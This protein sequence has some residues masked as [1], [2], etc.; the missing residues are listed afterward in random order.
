MLRP[1]GAS[2]TGD[3]L[4]P[5]FVTP[6]A[7]KSRFVPFRL[8]LWLGAT[9][10]IC[11]RLHAGDTAGNALWAAHVQPLF[12]Q[13]CFKCHGELKQKNGLDLTTPAAMLKG[14]DNGPAIVPGKPEDSLVYKFVLPG[15]EQHMPPKD[16]QLT[17]DEI[18]FVKMWI[19]ALPPNGAAA[20]SSTNQVGEWKG[21]DYQLVRPNDPK[22]L[23]PR[24]A[25]PSEAVDFYIERERPRI[26]KAL[27]GGAAGSQSRLKPAKPCDDRTFARRIHLDLIGRIPATAE[28]DAFLRDHRSNKRA[29]LI[30]RLLASPEH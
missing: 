12:S 11:G 14:G 6:S 18:A 24:R 27:T 26:A 22:V 20:S 28:L 4:N 15:A 19:A 23:P 25:T 10:A 3:N 9:A 1:S 13:H 8:S 30:D 16:Y 21:S 5:P 7:K 17:Q 29:A 2:K